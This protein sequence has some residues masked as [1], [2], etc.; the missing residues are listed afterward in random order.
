MKR[1]ISKTLSTPRGGV[2]I[3]LTLLAVLIAAASAAYSLIEGWSLQEGFYM[4]VITVST[5]GFQEVRPLSPWGR[6]VTSVL[7]V[8]GL[9]LVAYSSAKLGQS[10]LEGELFGE[11]GRRRMQRALDKLSGHF[12]VCGFGRMGR[13]VA[14]GLKKSGETVCVIDQSGTVEEE[15]IAGDY[16]YLIGDGTEDEI[17]KA[18]G[19]ERARALMAL[20]PSDAD[21]LYLTLTAKGINRNV[22]VIARSS[23]TKA[24]MKLRRGGADKVISPYEMAGT[25]VLEAALRPT[26]VEFMEV[27]THREQLALGW[28]EVE[29]EPDCLLAGRSIAEAEIRRRYGI[30]VV[31]IKRIDGKMVYNPAAS[32]VIQGGDILVAI[33]TKDSLASVEVA[34][35]RR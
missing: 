29:V 18:A 6:V 31:A 20:L 5:V 32:E 28:E 25:R 26:V 7:I 33:G 17:L 15:L 14:E 4:A 12:I 21:N 3:G 23:S 2:F 34:C 13:P 27:T 24:E 19:V 16:H 11:I 9:G 10:I 8:S 1:P 30:I 22:Q 35:S